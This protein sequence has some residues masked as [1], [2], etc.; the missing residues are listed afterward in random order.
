[1]VRSLYSGVA[2]MISHQGKMDVVGNNI[3]NVSTYGY[4]HSRATFRDV[5]YQTSK[6]A[7]EATPTSGGVN[8]SQIGYGSK[9]GSVDVNHSQSVMSTTGYTLDVAIAGEGYLQVMDNDGNIFYTKAGMLDIDSEGNVVDVN[10]NFVLGTS[11]NP[12]GKDPGSQKIRVNIPY[13]N[14]KAASVTDSI[15]SIGYTVS[16]SNENQAGNVNIVFA[17][18][19]KMP[20]GQKVM[21]EVTSSSIVVTLNANE[22]FNSMAELNME[23]NN[24]IKTAND[25]VEHPGGTFE[26]STDYPIDSR[27]PLTGRQIVNADFGVDVGEVKFATDADG[28]VTGGTLNKYMQILGVS[29]G[30]TGDSGTG[31]NTLSA[32]YDSATGTLSI[33]LGSGAGAGNTYTATVTK[34]QLSSSGSVILKKGGTSTTDYVTVSYPNLNVCEAYLDG[35][36]Q[37]Y[38]T[39][40]PSKPSVNL[41][42]G[43]GNFLLT[44]G[45]EGGEQT[46]ADLTGI[47]INDKGV[48]SA[49]HP[50]FGLLEIGRIDL[51]T[52]PNPAGLFQSGN[53]YFT[54]SL[55]S[56]APQICIAGTDGTGAILGGTLETSNTDLSQE[57]T[58]MITTQ[59]GFQACSRLITVSDT[60]LEELINLKR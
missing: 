2:G 50:T 30:F 21:A 29:D 18:S 24:A 19:T 17:S 9:L 46:V 40:A 54:E 10:G 23:M 33:S 14:A 58:D 27:W 37:V 15:N 44:G 52:F 39:M 22:E 35:G 47:S 55:N 3:S 28:E 1:M 51:A 5:Y 11:G 45:T 42:L 20:I 53:T 6:S 4:K 31:T 57:M 34:D 12:T 16:A 13:E 41:G 32:D 7:S 60:M 49:T 25:G 56:G 8:P 48:I 43:Q 38:V 26:V 59:R 36:D